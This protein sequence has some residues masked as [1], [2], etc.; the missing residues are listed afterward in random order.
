[1]ISATENTH[2]T[3]VIKTQNTMVIK[4]Q[5]TYTRYT[6]IKQPQAMQYIHH[7]IFTN[8]CEY[9]YRYHSPSV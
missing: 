4:T 1:M 2:N 3:M 9:T 6:L 7:A 8:F 5:H